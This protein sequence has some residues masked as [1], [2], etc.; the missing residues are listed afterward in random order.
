MEHSFHGI[1]KVISVPVLQGLAISSVRLPTT[2]RD[3]SRGQLLS[4]PLF[5]SSSSYK[6][7]SYQA[8][9]TYAMTMQ[10]HSLQNA[11]SLVPRLSAR[12]QT[13]EILRRKAWKILTREQR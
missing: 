11:T 10:P 6:Y 3:Q 13:R 7:A 9:S 8:S 2:V 4:Y 5:L 12:T 1:H